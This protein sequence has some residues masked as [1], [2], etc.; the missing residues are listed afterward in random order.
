MIRQFRPQDAT[1][2]SRLIHACLKSDFSL[3]PLL[4]KKILG[5]ETP[6]S[7]DERARLFYIAI[8][9][10]ENRIV[11]IAGLDMNEIRLLC[12]LPERQRGGIARTLLDHIK[13]MAPASLFSDIFVYSSIQAVGFYKACGFAEK[14]SFNFEIGGETLP[15]VFMTFPIVT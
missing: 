12:V 13:S 8:Y 15:T 3:T 7:M 5:M 1:P 11:G 14:G 4:R 6:Q 9:E 10:E 2:C